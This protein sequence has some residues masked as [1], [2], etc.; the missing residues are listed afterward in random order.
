MEFSTGLARVVDRAVV[1]AMGGA[2]VLLLAVI[3]A[4]N[5]LEIVSRTLFSISFGWIFEVNLLLAAWV[6]FLGIVP[7]YARRGDITVL[8]IKNLLPPPARRLF[9]AFVTLSSAGVYLLVG[10]YAI[11]LMR[12]QWP[13]RTPGTGFTNALYTMPLAIGCAGL[14]LVL[15]SQLLSGEEEGA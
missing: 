14:V 2:A 5:V 12:V 7:V 6:Y 10:W 4:I 13:M 11:Q 3:M 1:P 15:V 8:G 9:G